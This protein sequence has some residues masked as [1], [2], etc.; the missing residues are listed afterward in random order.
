MNG[1][2]PPAT[3]ARRDRRQRQPTRLSRALGDISSSRP[4]THLDA[5]PRVGAREAHEHRHVLR[6][7]RHDE[8]RHERRQRVDV[9]LQEL[10]QRRRRVRRVLD[11]VHATHAVREVAHV[12]AQR[13]ANDWEV[14]AAPQTAESAPC[15]CARAWQDS[16]QCEDREEAQEIGKELHGVVLEVECVHVLQ[17]S[18]H[19]QPLTSQKTL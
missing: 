13:D 6:E 4:S 19:C 9:A 2:A 18:S 1:D 10:A 17:T 7:E 14:G 15:Y 12:L 11:A 16:P 5:E 8:R 3:E